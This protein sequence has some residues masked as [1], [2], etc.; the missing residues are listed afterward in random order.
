MR[1]L[2]ISD[3][4]FVGGR[5]PQLANTVGLF[6]ASDLAVADTAAVTSWSPT[7]GSMSA[8]A[9]GTNKPVMAITG[10]GDRPAVRFTA[11]SSQTMAQTLS[12]P[13]TTWSVITVIK[14]ATPSGTQAPVALGS[15]PGTSY[16]P[17]TISSTWYFRPKFSA[18]GTPFLTGGTTDSNPHLV[19]CVARSTPAGQ[20]Y[21]DG[22]SVASAALT[23]I[24]FPTNLLLGGT[25]GSYFGGDIALVAVIDG[26]VVVD[27]NWAAFKAWVAHYYGLSLS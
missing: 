27:P 5:M 7:F 4:A 12:G 14:L 22:T 25:T 26:D 10:L 13:T 20:I 1:S 19:T 9:G 18:G 3:P 17:A 15:D 16:A 8:L 24:S 6:W 11:A 2:T 21:V 23:A